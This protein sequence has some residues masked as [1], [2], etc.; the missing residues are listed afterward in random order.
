MSKRPKCYQGYSRKFAR[1]IGLQLRLI[2][3]ERKLSLE[4]VE[5]DNEIK[6]GQLE[7]MELGFMPSWRIYEKLLEYYGYELKLVQLETK[8]PQKLGA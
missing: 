3:Y 7:N 5:Q 2:R 4:Q 6:T 8:K 1:I